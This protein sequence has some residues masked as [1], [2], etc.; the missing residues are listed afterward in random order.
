MDA[1]FK[2]GFIYSFWSFGQSHFWTLL[3]EISSLE[4]S[5]E[6]TLKLQ[7]AVETANITVESYNFNY[8]VSTLEL[9]DIKFHTFLFYCLK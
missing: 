6:M 9:Y 7:M 5:G 8:S 1:I 3:E 4:T 2:Y